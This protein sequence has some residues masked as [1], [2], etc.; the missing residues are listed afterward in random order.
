MPMKIMT[1]DHSM[2][3]I[4]LFNTVPTHSHSPLY[5]VKAHNLKISFHKMS[6][7]FFKNSTVQR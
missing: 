4:G 5:K 3:T 2:F 6:P 1:G 7:T